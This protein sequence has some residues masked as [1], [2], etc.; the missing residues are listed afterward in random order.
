MY[1]LKERIAGRKHKD[2]FFLLRKRGV[3]SKTDIAEHCDMTASTLARALDDLTQVGLIR[4]AGRGESRGGRRPILYAVDP[5]YG[6][7]FGLDIS[8][9]FSRLI[10]C[11]LSLRMID[12]RIWT[13]TTHMTPEV[14]LSQV[15][16]A[17]ESMIH[18]HKIAMDKMI[19]IGIGAVGPLDRNTGTLLEPLYFPA[20]GWNHFKLVDYLHSRLDMPIILDNGANSAI[21]AEYWQ[22]QSEQ[23]VEHLLYIRAGVGLRS[24]MMTNGHLVYGAVDME[25]SV[26][27]MIVQTDGIRHRNHAGNYGCLESYVSTYALEQ[28]A[29][30]LL[31]QGR[32]SVLRDMVTDI[33]R[34]D[35]GHLHR[36]L[37]HKD[38]LVVEL[39][40]QAATYFG[41]GVANLLNILHPEKVILGGP[42]ITDHPL[43]FRISTKIAL[44]NT[45]YYPVYNVEFKKEKLGE[46]TIAV[47]AAAMIV[48]ALTE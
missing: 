34:L 43:F 42:L 39:F 37:E 29:V 31:K 6:Y 40:S 27:Q 10:L 2:I 14:L 22:D 8:R 16:I 48:N 38:P 26:G 11:D 47:G 1:R 20:E 4:E 12:S 19:G 44:K 7:V 3:V 21:W 46:N 33:E 24:S 36:A 35:I 41:I 9:S 17:I 23:K 15:I 32:D 5:T 28:Q 30:S 18:T 25:G 45:Y 13:M